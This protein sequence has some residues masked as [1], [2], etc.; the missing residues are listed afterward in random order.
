MTGRTSKR[1]SAERAASRSRR[2]SSAFYDEASESYI[3]GPHR[4]PFAARLSLL[5]YASASCD[6]TVILSRLS[7]VGLSGLRELH[8]GVKA[9]WRHA[10]EDADAAGDDGSSVA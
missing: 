6:Q 3:L 10:H 1:S 4:H 7:G 2:S 8:A 5:L 9:A